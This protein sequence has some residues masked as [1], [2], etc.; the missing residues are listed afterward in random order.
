[1]F[2]QIRQAAFET[3]SS[4]CHSISFASGQVFTADKL[5]ITDGV[6]YVFP[7]D[8][9]CGPDEFNDACNK[10]SYA[11]VWAKENETK[12]PELLEMLRDVILANTEATSV[13]FEPTPDATSFPWGYI[14]HQSIEYGVPQ[15]VFKDAETLKNFIF[16]PKTV[17]YIR[18][19]NDIS[20]EVAWDGW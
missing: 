10:A 13:C 18:N 12:N 9:G 8:F 11:L 2:Q 15:Q 17:L 1:M 14:D 4:S 5:P 20:D 6:V 3:N 16:N 7:G 19:D